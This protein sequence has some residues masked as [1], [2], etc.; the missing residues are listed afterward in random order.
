M[1]LL[2]LK[3]AL[4]MATFLGMLAVA[5]IVTN[6]KGPGWRTFAAVGDFHPVP[7]AAEESLDSA[8]LAAKPR[9][10]FFE[11]HS[12]AMN[13]FYAALWRTERREKDAITRIVH[14]G[15]SPTTADLIT[16]D[17][18]MLLQRRFG[19]AGSGFTL[20]AKPWA[21]Y[22]HRNVRLSQSGWHSNPSSQAQAHDG[23][24]GLG[25]VM[26]VNSGAAWSRF[27]L[28][29]WFDTRAEVCFLREP[30]GGA[31]TVWAGD[32]RLGEVETDSPEKQSGFAGFGLPADA[33]DLTVRAEGPPVRLF[34]V[35]FEKPGPGVAYD[36][37]G[38]NGA[39]TAILAHVFNQQ[40]WTEQLRHRNPDLVV[41]N[42][43][44]NEAS[45]A[46]YIGK[47][48]A[49]EL[50]SAVS[51][52]RSAV[53]EASILVMS[54]MDRGERQAGGE[55]ETM[56]TI[57]KLVSIQQRLAGELGCAFFD[58]FHAMGGEG[59]MARWYEAQPRLVSADFLHP[60]PRGA[61]LVGALLYQA[62][63]EGFNAYKLRRMRENLR[64]ANA[65]HD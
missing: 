16:G 31:F 60:T 32:Q 62:L 29:D 14:Y 49:N 1:R 10:S 64:I 22:E 63:F 4:A 40:H 34:G 19:D 27:V 6:V 36:S 13:H 55:I 47:Y 42:Y 48:Y 28:E 17:V 45:Y 5:G 65:K 51:R 3:P 23:L 56:P 12:G 61:K 24:F 39:S 9:A 43:G 50:R 37:L 41:I 20:M 57:P 15:D 30:G 53:P 44:S 58:T 46:P 21:W 18:R 52:V 33:G 8:V 11:D 26:F 38:M 35:I 25:G 54:P 2:P 7:A 59:T